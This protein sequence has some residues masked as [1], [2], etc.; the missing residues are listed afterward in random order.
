[1]KAEGEKFLK[2]EVQRIRAVVIGDIMTDRYVFGEVSRI[3]P[4]APVPVNL[5]SSERS[6]LGGAANTAA[7]LSALGCRVYISGMRGEDESGHIL[8]HLCAESR[9]E[10]SGVLIEEDY[11]T[12]T[13]MRILG[14]RQQMM[15]LD[16]EK[17]KALDEKGMAEVL[18]WLD[19]LHESG[20]DCI[21]LSDYGKGFITPALA[22]AVIHRGHQWKIP[23]L[24]D[25]KGSD[26]GKY[27]GAYGITPNLKELS[28][29][30]GQAVPNEDEAV[31][32]AGLL[33][34]EQFHLKYLFV[35]RSEKGITSIGNKEIIHCPAMARD[36][37]DVSGAGDTV[38]AVMAA[39]L[40]AGKDSETAVKLANTAAGIAVS[41][42]GTYPVKRE[43]VLDAWE[44]EGRDIRKN[45]K[46]LTWG[47]AENKVR[48]W[49]EKGETVVFTNGCFDILHRGHLTYLQQ[50]AALGDHL[51]IGLNSDNSVRK[52]KG[53]ERPV[54]GE[55]D[56]AFML[57]SLRCVDDVVIFG[58]DTPE[59][60][61]SHLR[62]DI[63]VKG[64]DYRVEEVAGRQYA[65]KVEILPFVDG[66]STTKLIWKIQNHE[67]RTNERN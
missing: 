33:L 52:L 11:S 1:M 31:E 29:C 48:R 21:I 50:A 51:I 22:Q 67:E 49:K 13:K 57:A 61:L 16:F 45:Y 24:V 39:A 38:M 66:Y 41:R 28:E 54:N 27:T 19:G 35:T 46:P 30:F 2:E 14:A 47:E 62:P 4:E 59:K 65:G 8:H 7:N 25:P 17:K 60:L 44:S 34:R 9:I 20:I 56:R 15:R 64:G 42:V 43:E 58:E 36:V 32:K 63:L 10:D 12:I 40:A 26:W 5:V 53:A 23:V 18:R 55:E 3:S 37:F 6:V